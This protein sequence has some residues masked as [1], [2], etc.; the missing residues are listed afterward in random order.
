L[1]V[2]AVLLVGAGTGILI[3]RAAFR[4]MRDAPQVTGFI[5]SL[6]LSIMLQ[7]L[8]VMILSGQPRNFSFP[9]YL[10]ASISMGPLDVRVVDL[11]IIGLALGSMGALMLFVSRTRMGRAMRATAQNLEVA[12]LMGINVNRVIMI[13]FALVKTGKIPALE[14]TNQAYPTLVHALLPAGLRGLVAASLLAALMSSLSSVF[15]SASTLFTMDI[16][17]PLHPG[18]SERLL[19]WVGRVATTIMVVLGLAWIPFIALISDALYQYLQSVQA[20]IAP[21]IFAVFFLGVFSRRINAAGC[22]A[23]LV[24]GFVLGMARL[25]A[26][27]SKQYLTEGTLLYGFANLNFLYFCLV[28]LGVSIVVIV[29]VS[30]MTAP[31]PAEKLRGLT[32]WTLSDE[33]RRSTRASWNRWDISHTCAILGII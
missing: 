22:M 11:C 18:A 2:A 17:K 5:A 28:L 4:P 19:V 13:A 30:L 23:G 20:Y 3:E 15:N 31:P 14:S 25:V 33:N 16:Y 1:V 9:D 10:R 27:V 21:P 6:A 7:N 8:G 12:R 32:Y 24:S 29:G 26:E